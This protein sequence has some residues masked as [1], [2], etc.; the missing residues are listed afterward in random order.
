MIGLSK[1][2]LSLLIVFISLGSC[3]VMA[4]P[5]GLMEKF[6]LADDRQAMLA[7]LIPGSEEHFFFHCLHYQNT[8]QLEKADA[9]IADWL[10]ANKGRQS[11]SIRA[12]VDRQRLLTY[13]DSPQKTI[14]HLIKRMGVQLDHAPP[15]VQGER[16]YPSEFDAALLGVDRLVKDALNRQDALTAAGMNYVAEQFHKSDTAGLKITLHDFLARVD[17]PYIRDLDQLVIA[18]LKSRKAK[19]VAFGILQAHSFL[20]L[21][22]MERVGKAVPAVLDDNAF[23]DAWLRHLR[24]DG[25]KDISQQAD[26]RLQFLQRVHDY[27]TTLPDSYN[28]LKACATFRLLEAKMVA[29][30]YDQKLFTQYL[31]LPRNSPIIHVTWA[32]R[33]FPKA[34]LNQN[35]L[36]QALLSPIGNEEAL[37]RAHLNHFLVAANDATEFAEYLKPEYLRR[38][39][40]ETKLMAGIGDPQDWYKMLEPQQRQRVRD[41]AQ[42]R[43]APQNKIHFSADD[44]TEL[45]VDVKNIQELVVR[46]YEINTLAYYRSNEKQLD[47]DIDL[48]GL[49]PTLEQ[50][51]SYNQPAIQRHRE[52]IGLN[53]ISGRGVWIVDLVG[54]GL[55]ARAIIRRGDIQHASENVADGML[56]TIIDENEQ[57]IPKATMLVAGQELVANE[58]GQVVLPPVNQNASRRAIISDGKVSRQITIQQPSEQYSLTA[59]MFIDRTL[60]QTGGNSKL[61]IRPRLMMRDQEVDSSMLTDVS[62]LITATDTD[63]VDTTAQFDDLKLADSKELMI[64]VR[65]PA[66]LANLRVDISGSIAGLSDRR[67]RQ[68][69]TSKTWDIAGIRATNHTRDAFLTR[70]GE[71]YVIEVRGRSGEP[72]SAETVSIFVNTKYRNLH[73]QQTLQTDATGRINLGKLPGATSLRFS[74]PSGIAH[75]RHLQMDRVIW[76]R[77]IHSLSGRHVQLPV[78]GDINDLK[79]RYRLFEIR[80]G[81]FTIDASKAITVADGFLS[82]QGLSAGDYRL[83]DK[84]TNTSTNIVLVEGPVAGNIATGKIRHQSL[85]PASGLSIQSVTHDAKGVSI[86]LG[87]KTDF[88]RIHVIAK[89]YFDDNDPLTSLALPARRLYGRTISRNSSGYI[90]DLRLGD[91]Y[92]YVLRRR[93]AA[94]FPGVMLP[95]PGLILNPWETE[96]TTSQSQVAAGGD[97]VGA[98]G[99]APKSGKMRAAKQQRQQAAASAGSDFDFLADSGVLIS[100]LVPDK[101]GVVRISADAIDGLPLIQIVACNGSTAML[102]TLATKLDAPELSDLRLPKSLPP[103]KPFGFER[104]VTIASKDQPLDIESLGSAQLQ[105]YGHVGALLKLYKTLTKDARLAEFD[106]LAVWHQLSEAQKLAAYTRLAS[107]E[108]HLFL[109][110]HDR[111]FFD[112]IIR[113]YLSNKKEKQFIDHW[114]LEHD[115]SSYQVLW[116][117]NQLNAAERSLLALRVPEVAD[118]VRREFAEFI[119]KQQIDHDKIR[120]SFESALETSTLMARDGGIAL[121]VAKPENQSLRLGDLSEDY[122]EIDGLQDYNKP[123]RSS[124]GRERYKESM[125]L[126]E[127]KDSD[128]DDDEK[129]EVFS[130]RGPV[131]A[132]GR[133]LSLYQELDTT[134][135]WA[136]SNWDHVRVVGGPDPS[137]LITV[138]PFWQDVASGKAMVSDDLLMPIQ[139][140][141]SVL[142]A[143]AF[144]GLPLKPGDIALP[145]KA[146]QTYAPEHP[147]AVIT[148]RLLQ[149]A[150]A[151][152]EYGILVGQRFSRVN[153]TQEEAKIAPTE[154]LV[155][156][157]YRGRIVVSNPTDEQLTVDVFWQTPTGS[158]PLA[159]HQKTN[160][161]TIT[162]EPFAVGSVEYQFY[163]S[164]A[165]EFVHYPATVATD[166]KL[167]ARGEEKKFLAVQSASENETVTWQSV[168]RSGTPEQIQ[169]FL[170]K[171]NL[172]KLD[173]NLVAHRMSDQNTYQVVIQAL[174]EAQ[175]YVPV[176]YAYSLKHRDEPQMRQYLAAS[177]DMVSTVG[178]RLKSAVLDV[179]PIEQRTH[180]LL[181][182]A[183]LVRARIHQLGAENEI[184]NPAFLRQ[185]QSFVRMLAYEESIPAEEKLTLAYYLLLQNRIEEAIQRFTPVKRD[186]VDTKLQYDYLNAYLCMHRE[187]FEQAEEIT[188]K[189][190][191]YKVPRWKIRFDEIATQLVQRRGLMQTQQLASVKGEPAE[192][193]PIAKGSGDL[194][195]I[196]RQQHQANAAQQLPEVVV[197]V[198]GDSLRIDHRR[199]KEAKLNLYGVDLEL[200]FSKAPFVRDD[201]KKLAMVRPMRTETLDFDEPTGIGRFDLQGDLRRQTLLVEVVAG[202]S[203]STALYYGGEVTTYISESFGQLQTTDA[204]SHQPIAAAYVK[205]YARYPDGSVKFYKDG[206]TDSRGRFDYSSI[207]A[208]DARGAQRFAILVLSEEKGATLHDIA[209]PTQ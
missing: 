8:R 146:D 141:H 87:G 39:F 74:L 187:A 159:G 99:S 208:A 184:L 58:K 97:A 35:F 75:K 123:S 34:D 121:G 144:C 102:R 92:Q 31:K 9:V 79:Q 21:D 200:L 195:L 89:R 69:Q 85:S 156:E 192:G 41:A 199:S 126:E 153:A 168:V 95:Q 15:A 131:V 98:A 108:L 190:A 90:S 61:L 29:G 88:A 180:E 196:D 117:Y 49:V 114:V 118:A 27:V 166:G 140:R 185:Y 55:R 77:E 103:E 38:V 191:D 86:Q 167:I 3:E 5:I 207:S 70:D 172:R 46:A 194:A 51:I 138:N 129:R 163:F 106:E 44:P 62:V 101:D 165:G 26:A 18:E 94:K 11:N 67:Q 91:E 57:V 28:S 71:N 175:L 84:A 50:K 203:R 56:F 83:L 171:A 30:N 151:D 202:A 124:R 136:E 109:W 173:W 135:Q 36:D 54:K 82:I 104:T 164:Q 179:Q 60:L 53:E 96:E 115:L 178:P 23:V 59:G 47:T 152:R 111:E 145:E 43:L 7:E 81:N 78:A 68:V 107:H 150:D 176:L 132:G 198:D 174:R 149:L 134:K 182:Y 209:P 127:R 142:V 197:R 66:R 161:K 154:F 181:E 73:V 45:I 93:F 113:P 4:E 42:L 32:K 33:P 25:D 64:P 14:D 160:S 204:K 183:P 201:L 162:L 125:R 122:D 128:F 37:V 40:A 147:V 100:N 12:M 157:A 186:D 1:K 80:G 177:A 130:R 6:A 110:S 169:D 119:A 17:G 48:D 193:Q 63:G 65:V 189:Y 2:V 72:I 170:S 16:R 76:P 19:D 20:T 10:A 105:V 143:L 120:Y 133:S 137:G 52:T 148:K 155:G 139:N 158:I 22:E 13:G 112:Q 205:V 24:P 206:Y 116:R 188:A